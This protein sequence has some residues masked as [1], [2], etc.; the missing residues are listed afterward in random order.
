MKAHRCPEIIVEGEEELGD[1]EFCTESHVERQQRVH[2]CLE[3]ETVLYNYSSLTELQQFVHLQLKLVRTELLLKSTAEGVPGE[4]AV[5]LA[6]SLE[7][8][9]SVPFN[10]E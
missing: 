4:R 9:I 10:V 6:I 1:K 8:V 7:P 2:V 3:G 5:S